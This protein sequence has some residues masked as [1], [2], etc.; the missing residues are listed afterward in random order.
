[1]K[2]SPVASQATP[3]SDARVAQ[4]ESPLPSSGN[5]QSSSVEAKVRPSSARSRTPRG[6]VLVQPK[7]SFENKKVPKEPSM[8]PPGFEHLNHPMFKPKNDPLAV[9]SPSGP[10]PKQIAAWVNEVIEG[11]TKDSQKELRTNLEEAERVW[12]R[13]A[14]ALRPDLG[15]LATQWGL[16]EKIASKAKPEGLLQIVAI[17]SYLAA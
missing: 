5:R 3:H 4:A 9:T 8:P 13:I 12:N 7:L 16:P 2:K 15:K 1:M 17:A 14:I 11:L 10:L 6:R